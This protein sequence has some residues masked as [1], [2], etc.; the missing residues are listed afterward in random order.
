VNIRDADFTSTPETIAR[1]ERRRL[2]RLP[3]L[4][5]STRLNVRIL[6]K[7]L[8]EERSRLPGLVAE[9]EQLEAKHGKQFPDP[10]VAAVFEK[11]EATADPH[12]AS[13]LLTK[14]L[15]DQ[16]ESRRAKRRKKAGGRTAP[17]HSD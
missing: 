16:R 8:D 5:G 12:E 14:L 3:H 4:I 10:D 11:I 7:Q 13:I 1:Q 2:E 6:E 9:L 17:G 15:D